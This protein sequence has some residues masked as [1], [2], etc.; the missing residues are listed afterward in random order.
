MKTILSIQSQVAGARVGN[1]VAA[2]AMERLGVRVLQLPTVL[3][4]RRPD[5]GPPGGGPVAADM[6]AAMIDGLAADSLLG[7]IDAV[8]TGY[9][10]AAD[11]APVILDCVAR[12][13]AAN[14]NAFFV[15]D[16]VL[17]DEGRTFVKDEVAEAVLNSLCAHADWLTPNLYEL[18]LITGAPLEG[19][20]EARAAA[21]RIHKPVL[22]SSIR[23]A[24]G[25]GNLLAAPTG[26]WFCETARLP[27]AP[28]GTGD[29]LSA[30]YVAR[31]VRGDALAVALEGA[32]GA[33]YDV[34]VRSLAAESEDLLLPEAQDVLADPVTW[35]RA[36]FT[37]LV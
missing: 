6:L 16:P 3:L 18:G 21:K 8:L 7:D 29:L 34:I 28:K 15:C 33:V 22:C 13:K 10:G 1:S 31:R 19:L 27:R 11:Q 24:L 5:H 35:P 36:R 26:D 9:I 30:L 17:G 37:E 25:L 4:G 14:P 20:A 2:F 23:T 32:T 12:V